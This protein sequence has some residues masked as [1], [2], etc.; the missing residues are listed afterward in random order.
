VAQYQ[1]TRAEWDASRLRRI[2]PSGAEEWPLR[3][4]RS[5]HGEDPKGD[6][7][8]DT[9]RPAPRHHRRELLPPGLPKEG[10]VTAGNASGINDGA[11]ALVLMSADEARRW[12]EALAKIVSWATTG[13][14]R[15]SG[16][17]PVRPRRPRSR[18]PAGRSRILILSRLMKPAAQ[19]VRSARNWAS[20]RPS[21]I[22]WRRI[23][24]GHRSA[25]RTR[26]TTL[27]YRCEARRQEGPA[28]LQLGGWARHASSATDASVRN[29]AIPGR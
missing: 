4:D 19:A 24:L 6:V 1:I 18:R 20:I 8:V 12:R 9:G 10:S 15:R 23:A 11:A 27:L 7:V 13:S 29:H 21:S 3:D 14:I 25:G 26:V 22:Q 28:T 17:G 16:I 2:R 5:G